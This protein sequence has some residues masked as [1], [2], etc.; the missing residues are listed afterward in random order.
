MKLS[1][2]I[3]ALSLL[4]PAASCCAAPAQTL[5]EQAAAWLHARLQQPGDR[6]DIS[7]DPARHLQVPTCASAP[8]MSMPSHARL[9]TRMGVEVSCPSS[10][11]RI[12]VPL[13]V[14]VFRNVLVTTRPLQRGDGLRVG[15]LRSE[16]RDVTRLGYGY[17]QKFDQVQGRTL[18]RPLTAGSV[19]VPGAL[20]RRDAV[21]AGDQVQLVADLGGVQ[22]RASAV[23]LGS[24]D[25]GAR[26]RVRNESSGRTLTAVVQ[27]PGVLEALP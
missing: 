27:A 26:L 20:A 9:S 24:G 23:A 15:D 17:V 1:P 21:R 10:G 6:V 18:A 14:H 12:R 2:G 8:Q 22:V 16:A 13:N 5:R 3:L 25:V 7:A 11:W 4:L 19:L